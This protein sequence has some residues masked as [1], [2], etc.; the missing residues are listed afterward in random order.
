MK[1]GSTFFLRGAVLALGA[2][3]LAI[4]IFAL[5]AIWVTIGKEYPH[6]SAPYGVVAAMYVAA[7]PFF[8]ALYQ[9][10][11][12][13]N[14]IDKNIAFSGLSV[15]ALKAIKYCAVAVSVVFAA[16]MPFFYI[17][18]DRDDAPGLIVIG[19]ILTAAPVVVAV[20]AAVLQRL[21]HQAIA[22]KKENDLTV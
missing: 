1:R 13:L 8:V 10:L 12:L 2:A 16:S 6:T 22:I 3:V 9:T 19:M 21:L 7:V 5:P 4:C 20:F 17:W 18:G 14:Y 15:D 11:R